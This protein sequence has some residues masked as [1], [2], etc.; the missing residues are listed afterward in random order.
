MT[1]VERKAN[2]IGEWLLARAGMLAVLVF[3]Q[4]ISIGVVAWG[5]A[6][7]NRNGN[8]QRREL[9]ANF[10]QQL[11]ELKVGQELLK[12]CSSPGG[13][14][15]EE[16]ISASSV[17]AALGSISGSV[18]VMLECALVVPPD[19]RTPEFLSECRRKGETHQATIIQSARNG[20]K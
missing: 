14:C 11:N 9:R 15:F 6:E 4:F 13:K 18:M 12:D 8:D 1:E 3:M 17:G 16:Q 20:K 19:Q 7:S 5:I 2:K 10:N